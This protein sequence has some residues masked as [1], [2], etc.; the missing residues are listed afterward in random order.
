[1]N[2]LVYV[3]EVRNTFS[4]TNLRKK[5]KVLPT[6]RIESLSLV[7]R[8][9][10]LA[11]TLEAP[12]VVDSVTVVVVVVPAAVGDSSMYPTYVLLSHRLRYGAICEGMCIDI[13][14]NSS[15]HS[16]LAGKI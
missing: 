3:R 9:V 5:A 11:E 13:F 1:M 14:A 4:M 8:V 2:R 10:L 12:A 16:T 6:D 7:S 15:S